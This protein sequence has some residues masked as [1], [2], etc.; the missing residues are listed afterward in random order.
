MNG[1]RREIKGKLSYWTVPST[2]KRRVRQVQKEVIVDRQK[3]GDCLCGVVGLSEEWNLVLLIVSSRINRIPQTSNNHHHN[4]AQYVLTTTTT[5]RTTR[6]HSIVESRFPPAQSRGAS[7]MDG[8]PRGDD[9]RFHHPSIYRNRNRNRTSLRVG[10]PEE[11]TDSDGFCGGGGG[12]G[13]GREGGGRPEERH[14]HHH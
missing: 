6:I 11:E 13:G 5:T 12:G 2:N 1:R 7:V 3:R 9:D 10:F 4:E 8:D 14:H